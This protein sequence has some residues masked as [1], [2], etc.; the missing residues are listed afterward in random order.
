MGF[1][2][3]LMISLSTGL[4]SSVATI[5]ALKTD[6]SW[7]KNVQKDQETRIRNLEGKQHG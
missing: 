2:E 1:V 3:T 6:I 4:F 5:A 7:I